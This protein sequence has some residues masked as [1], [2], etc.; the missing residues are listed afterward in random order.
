MTYY[1]KNNAYSSCQTA[2]L[3]RSEFLDSNI[4]S[5][6]TTGIILTVYSLNNKSLEKLHEYKVDF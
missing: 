2:E 1:H 6:L 5:V 4:K 3:I